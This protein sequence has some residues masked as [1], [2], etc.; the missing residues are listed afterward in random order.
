MKN[1]FSELRNIII[2]ADKTKKSLN[3]EKLPY[4]TTDLSPVLSKDNLD[5]HFG[6]LAKTY[7]NRFNNDEGDLDFNYAGGTLH[8][9]FFSQFQSPSSS[10][11][12]Y[13]SS[14]EFIN[15]H[16]DNFNKFKENVTKIAMGIQGSGW[17]YLS[18][19]GSIKTIKNHELKPDIILLIDWWEHSW[20]ID[21]GPD[22]EKYLT[23]IWRIINWTVI[24]DRINLNN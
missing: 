14:L 23:N 22:K 7:V 2:E 11:K 5:V 1:S 18:K 4:A 10:N 8:N 15:K 17:V 6:I 24:N 16:H 3:L 19:N 12:P 13:G 20:F 9:I 21:Y